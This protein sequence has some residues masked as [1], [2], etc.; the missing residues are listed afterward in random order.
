M[1]HLFMTLLILTVHQSVPIGHISTITGN[2]ST[3][4]LLYHIGKFELIWGPLPETSF[5]PAGRAWRNAR[6]LLINAK[7]KI[8]KTNCTSNSI[9]DRNIMKVTLERFQTLLIP[10]SMSLWTPTPFQTG[11]WKALKNCDVMVKRG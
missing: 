2:E 4:A 8:L 11:F 6:R 9:S 10:N 1:L 7:H 5:S 3:W